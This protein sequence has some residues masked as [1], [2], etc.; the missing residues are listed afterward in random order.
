[1]KPVYTEEQPFGIF[2]SLLNIKDKA[3]A[4]TFSLVLDKASVSSGKPQKYVTF[5]NVVGM[6][7][8]MMVDL[9]RIYF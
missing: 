4:F 2:R 7:Q 5:V 8:K 3:L 1:M 6:S 9:L